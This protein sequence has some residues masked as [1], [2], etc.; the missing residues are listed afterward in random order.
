M[1]GIR[2]T[3]RITTFSIPNLL[4]IQFLRTLFVN[5]CKFAVILLPFYGIQLAFLFMCNPKDGTRISHTLISKKHI[6]P[7]V[8]MS[9][10]KS[11][12]TI[13]RIFTIIMKRNIQEVMAS[14]D[15]IE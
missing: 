15:W 12:K 10:S 14:L 1:S 8:K 9:Y 6:Y 4:I 2:E 11:L 13:L 7:V 5:E 3:S